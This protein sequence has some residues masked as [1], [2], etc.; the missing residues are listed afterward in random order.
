MTSQDKFL[1]KI[2]NRIGDKYSA[3]GI[4]L[5]L[6]NADIFYIKGN[7]PHNSAQ[8]GYDI[9]STWAQ[10][11]PNQMPLLAEALRNQEVG[12]VDLAE[13]VEAYIA[14][15]KTHLDYKYC[16]DHGASIKKMEAEIQYQGDQI[17][18]L[19]NQNKQL[20]VD[21]AKGKMAY[22]TMES[23]HE[24]TK[25]TLRQAEQRIVSLEQKTASSTTKAK[26][27]THPSSNRMLSLESPSISFSYIE[28]DDGGNDGGN[29]Y[30]GN[31]Y[32]IDYIVDAAT[33]GK[34]WP[35]R[36]HPRSKSSNYRS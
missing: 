16:K 28:D 23:E 34:G 14:G 6:N 22:E 17:H 32:Y 20:E 36:S 29:Y 15:A 35:K 7:N 12:R 18:N 10:R 2:G 5:G 21:V 31:N 11:Q 9:L 3:L 27:E 33:F 8:W 19:K 1:L 26:L 25:Y 24:N 4:Q 13:M 30:G